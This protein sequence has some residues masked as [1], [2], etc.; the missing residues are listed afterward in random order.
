M[1]G[2]IWWTHRSAPYM[3][4]ANDNMSGYNDWHLNTLSTTKTLSL[5]MTIPTHN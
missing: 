5:P 3:D 4:N 1:A 2:A